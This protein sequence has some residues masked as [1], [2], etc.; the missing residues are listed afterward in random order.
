M[1]IGS[2]NKPRIESIDQ[3]RG[4]AI[5]AMVAVNFLA[6]VAIIPAIL[7]HAPDI[8]YTIADIIAP[9]FIFSIALSVAQSV[10]AKFPHQAAPPLPRR[11]LSDTQASYLSRHVKRNLILIGIGAIISAGEQLF[12]PSPSIIYIWGVLQAIGT[13]GLI[14]TAF[15]FTRPW[16]RLIVG[17]L[18]LTIYQLMLDI[19]FLPIVLESEHGGLFGAVSWAGLLMLSSVFADLFRHKRRLFVLAS[20]AAIGLGIGLGFTPLIPISKNRVSATYILVSLG[21]SGI[22]YYLFYLLND[23]LKIKIP[24]LSAF[25]QNPLTLYVAHYVLLSIFVL[26][27]ASW[28]YTDEGILLSLTQLIF[29]IG[30]LAVG[31]IILEKNKIRISL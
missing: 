31:A 23:L 22:I 9:M 19:S 7:K 24:L 28:W 21:G 1:N 12:D 13:A 10:A 2:E 14:Y 15:I 20:F 26:P 8:G 5:I 11:R 16:L 27:G 30:V 6:P 3:F 4:F 25:G 18:L 29:L 17:C